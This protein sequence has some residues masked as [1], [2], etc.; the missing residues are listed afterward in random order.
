MTDLIRR[1]ESSFALL[2][3][4]ADLAQKIARTEFVPKGLR[5]RPDA[6]LACVL[7]GHEAGVPPM[8]ALQFIDVIEGRPAQ[9]AQLARMLIQSKGHAIWVEESTNTRCT[10]CGRR[11]GEEH[12]HRATWTLDDA[13]RAGLVGKENW[14]K[15]PRQ[16]LSA[17]ATGDLARMA[18]ADVLG[19]MPYLAEELEDGG[20]FENGM[21]S[22]P[23]LGGQLG[24]APA[25]V[26]HRRRRGRPP[27]LAAPTATV[28]SNEVPPREEPP[29]EPPS[30]SASP[31]RGQLEGSLAEQDQHR[32]RRH[33]VC[34]CGN[35]DDDTVTSADAVAPSCS[36]ECGRQMRVAFTEPEPLTVRGPGAHA[37]KGNFPAS[38]ARDESLFDRPFEDDGKR[39]PPTRSQ[40]RSQPPITERQSGES[41]TLNQ[42]I[43]I[44]CRELGIDRAEL[45]Q[46]MT[47]KTRGRDLTREEA[48]R[49]LEHLRELRRT[50]ARTL[51]PSEG[52]IEQLVVTGVKAVLEGGEQFYEIATDAGPLTT[53]DSAVAGRVQ[54]WEELR[55]PLAVLFRVKNRR[56]IILAAEP[57]TAPAGEE[58]RARWAGQ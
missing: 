18:F 3:P 1:D 29:L 41:L 2:G 48:G 5:G 35:R 52:F 15:Y 46:E 30:E 54:E 26:T 50:K 21:Q 24:T 38:A 12:V 19:G 49:V 20:A 8:T 33:L 44:L 53:E 7:A 32:I 13:Q 4:A 40:R 22:A 28:P 57:A 43:A 6:I 27:K 11:A 10:W 36:A 25:P 55:T 45:I 37:D 56:R 14:R 16:M 47:G 51:P 42:Q 9:R 58:L 17:R 39:K 31:L 34:D 23:S